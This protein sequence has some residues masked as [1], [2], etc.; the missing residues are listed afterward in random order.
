M[1]ANDPFLKL[2]K[3]SAGQRPVPET[4]GA[5]A[6][7]RSAPEAARAAATQQL[8]PAVYFFFQLATAFAFVAEQ[9][10]DHRPFAG[11][12]QQFNVCR[13]VRSSICSFRAYMMRSANKF[14]PR[15]VSLNFLRYTISSRPSSAPRAL[16]AM[17]SANTED[18]DK[19]RFSVDRQTDVIREEASASRLQMQETISALSPSVQQMTAVKAAALGYA[20]PYSVQTRCAGQSCQSYKG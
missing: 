7:Q 19:L 12:R 4:A 14:R 16:F 11:R 2:Q 10:I 5:D 20:V 8:T 13:S 6:G 18:V 9:K 3:R 1:R 15:R 17:Q